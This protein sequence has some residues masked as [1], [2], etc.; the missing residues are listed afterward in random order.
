[1]WEEANDRGDRCHGRLCPLSDGGRCSRFVG[2]EEQCIQRV[3]LRNMLILGRGLSMLR[4]LGRML[5]LYETPSSMR[6]IGMEMVHYI[7]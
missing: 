2:R 4:G 7:F 1:V 6:D 3:F 5:Y